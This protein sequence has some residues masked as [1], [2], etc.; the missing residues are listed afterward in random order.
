[1]KRK[2]LVLGIVLTLMVV[3]AGAL[4]A[5][6]TPGAGVDWSVTSGGGTSA[7]G[8]EI[9]LEGTLGEPIVGEVVSGSLSLGQG[10]WY[11]M[12]PVEVYLPVVMK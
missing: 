2:L 6:A 3:A 11:A 10:Y 12:D 9:T 5:H 8:G 7:S 1:M 4:I